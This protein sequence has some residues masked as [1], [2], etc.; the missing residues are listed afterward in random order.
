[1]L[2]KWQCMSMLLTLFGCM[3]TIFAFAGTAAAQSVVS[4]QVAKP[5]LRLDCDA[6][7]LRPIV[8]RGSID[9]RGTLSCERPSQLRL[10]ITLYKV[11][12]DHQIRIG[13]AVVQDRDDTLRVSV[14]RT[15]QFGRYRSEVVGYAWDVFR[16]DWRRVAFARSETVRAACFF[17]PR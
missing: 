12:G 1:M 13:S 17:E 5:V 4:H 8:H 14:D 11:L 15:C 16:Q 2:K 3:F 9:A 10:Q 7:A 6:K